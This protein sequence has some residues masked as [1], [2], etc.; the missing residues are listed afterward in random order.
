M[1][2]WKMWK[3][4]RDRTKDILVKARS[5]IGNEECWVKGSLAEDHHGEEM[6]PTNPYACRWCLEGAIIKAADLD[7]YEVK[8]NI[9]TPLEI[10][11]RVLHGTGFI[12]F[13]DDFN[14]AED[15]THKDVLDL[16][17]K[18]IEAADRFKEIKP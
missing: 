7:G 9:P 3:D 6:Y 18:A 12:G 8:D 16:L 4:D 17:D 15:T 10:T 13:L 14:D 5:L 11:V 2:N 1:L